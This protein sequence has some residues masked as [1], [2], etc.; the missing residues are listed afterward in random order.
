MKNKPAS[1]D[2]SNAL[3]TAGMVHNEKS[4]RRLAILQY[5]L[6]QPYRKYVILAVGFA[7]I[8]FGF[9]GGL[10]LQ[11]AGVCVFLGCLC[12]WFSKA[13]AQVT[14]NRM[15]EAIGGKYPRSEL[16]FREEEVAVTDGKEW[17][18]M[19][20]GMIQR[21]IEDKEYIYL[22]LTRATSYMID[23]ATLEPADQKAF[24]AFLEAR[25]SLLTENTPSLFR[26][27]LGAVR[28]RVKNA[29]ARKSREG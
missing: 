14:A 3:Y 9:F 29:K 12:L 10:N 1:H 24:K 23:K 16:Y 13:P 17:F 21:V 8:L 15:V 22:W 20:Y 27:N 25:T 7:M 2:Y 26:F 6:F 18:Y 19:P 28:R 5:D 4:I 11:G